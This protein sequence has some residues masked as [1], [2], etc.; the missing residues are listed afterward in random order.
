MFKNLF[1]IVTVVSFYQ[2]SM[3]KFPKLTNSPDAA[4]F[5]P[6]NESKKNNFVKIFSFSKSVKSS[7]NLL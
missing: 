3:T 4:N 7:L 1:Q 5:G 6:F 2:R